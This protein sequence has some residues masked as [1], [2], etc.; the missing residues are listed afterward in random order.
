MIWLCSSQAELKHGRIAML[1]F[2][3]LVVPEFVRI[4]GGFGFVFTRCWAVKKHQ[5]RNKCLIAF[6]NFVG[7]LHFHFWSFKPRIFP[8]FEFPR[9]S[10]VQ[11]VTIFR[12][13]RGVRVSA[14]RAW[15]VLRRQDS[16]GSAQ[17]LRWRS[18]LPLRAGCDRH[19][20]QKGGGFLEAFEVRW[21]YNND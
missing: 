4:P 18:I 19:L 11:R 5:L 8:L 13:H 6:N 17:R 1:A 2:V 12:G 10:E 21:M 9:S 15:T 14:F 3:G 16:G 20:A 7:C